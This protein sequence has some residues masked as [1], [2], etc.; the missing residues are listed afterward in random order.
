MARTGGGDQCAGDRRADERGEVEG[1]G[2][3]WHRCRELRARCDVR[4]R[5]LHR[6]VRRRLKRARNR[7]Q[8]ENGRGTGLSCQDQ[9]RREKRDRHRSRV[10]GRQNQDAA[11]AI[12][13]NA[14]PWAEDKTRRQTHEG[15]QT[16]HR[17]PIRSPPTSA[18][19]AR[20]APSRRPSPQ[21]SGR[22]G[23]GRSAAF[24]RD[25]PRRE[26]RSSGRQTTPRVS[27][28]RQASPLP[29]SQR[30]PA[31]GPPTGQRKS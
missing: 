19:R 8:D 28:F 6:P 26:A 17:W 3:K 22:S 31:Q 1:D 24:G 18:S 14:S 15:E 27:G 20:D 30:Q 2:R 5:G 4:D 12:C 29:R 25:Q 16:H 9:Y 21:A 13:Q 7:S 10:A 11:P 23:R